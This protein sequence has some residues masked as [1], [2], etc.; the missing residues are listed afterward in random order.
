M[1]GCQAE[2]IDPHRPSAQRLPMWGEGV[3]ARGHD[4]RCG[5]GRNTPIAVLAVTAFVILIKHQNNNV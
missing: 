1:T 5:K 4:G 2:G 3:E